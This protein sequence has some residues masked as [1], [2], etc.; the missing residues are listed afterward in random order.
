[1]SV[2]KLL[3]MFASQ[4]YE[5]THRV[6]TSAN[7][8]RYPKPTRHVIDIH[9]NLFQF[10]LYLMPKS[11]ISQWRKCRKIALAGDL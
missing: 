8:V 3:Q 6:Q 11:P 2:G 5:S 9:P 4:P 1:M 10:Q 7:A